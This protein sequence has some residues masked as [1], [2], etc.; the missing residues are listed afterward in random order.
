MVFATGQE[1]ADRLLSKR[2]KHQLFKT[3]GSDMRLT[4]SS[5]CCGLAFFPVSSL[6]SAQL[7]AI[8]HS[9]AWGSWKNRMYQDSSRCL[10]SAAKM[11]PAQAAAIAIICLVVTID[12]N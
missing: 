6:N 11:P 3:P 8:K 1:E 7:S 2:D 9:S 12:D 4:Y 10:G 5:T